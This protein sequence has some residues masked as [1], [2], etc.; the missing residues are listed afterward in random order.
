ML[1]EKPTDKPV[2]GFRLGVKSKG[3]NGMA[4]DL[5]FT[6]TKSKLDEVVTEGG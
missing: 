4:Y 5:S 2:V 1:K 3:C 6:D